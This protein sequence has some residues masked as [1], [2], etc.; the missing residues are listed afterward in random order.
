MPAS[1]SCDK[2]MKRATALHAVSHSIAGI[3][4][5]VTVF[6]LPAHAQGF[7]PVRPIEFVVHTG[8]GGGN[9]VLARRI[10]SI[11]DQE[12]LLP[13]RMTVVNKPGGGSMTAMTY[14]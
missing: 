9:D 2:Q 4:A 11:T 8:P 5:V 10:A 6:A 14:V 3:A 13:V 7:K 1:R 12:K